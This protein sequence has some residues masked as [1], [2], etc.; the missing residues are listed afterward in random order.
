VSSPP[1]TNPA[2]SERSS[3]ALS[4]SESGD[5]ADLEL[6]RGVQLSK[7]FAVPA[8]RWK[9][10]Q[11]V[12]AV[13]DA[14][15]EIG[16]AETVGLVGESGSGKT[17][18][19]RL[20]LRLA[21]PTYG[22]VWFEGREI[23]HY[24]ERDLRPLRRSLQVLF[25]DAAAALDERWTVSEIVAE[26]LVIHDLVQTSRQRRERV[27][28]LLHTVGLSAELLDR[29]PAELSSGQCQR[30]SIAR[31]L[32]L[33]PRFIV[34][35]EPIA[36]LDASDQL[37]VVELLR[38][39]QQRERHSYLFI[40]HDLR[41]VLSLSQRVLVMYAGRVVE[42]AGARELREAARHPY[43][44]AL[45][46]AVPEVDPKKRRLRVVLEGEPPSPFEL[47]TGCPFH[48][49]CPRAHADPC[50]R[51]MPGLIPTTPGGSHEVACWFPET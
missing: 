23:T 35:D 43:T 3:S 27:A 38:A 22:Q 12:R 19:G 50:E 15:I 25:Q 1:S 10:A 26:P 48:P 46:N 42:S 45:L 28:E 33:S 31:A 40:S 9:K 16:P 2:A 8:G 32:A 41:M 36:A 49:R 20:L 6:L 44:R 47:V 37:R 17:T 5:D 30:V 18:L 21:E 24:H 7:F 11:I 13:Q 29:R 51:E 34:C 39:L 14:S 4:A